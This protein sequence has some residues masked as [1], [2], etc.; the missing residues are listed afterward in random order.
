MLL[1][2]INKVA[3]LQAQRR[4]IIIG[5]NHRVVVVIE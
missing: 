5:L 2:D 4:R 3:F 1:Q